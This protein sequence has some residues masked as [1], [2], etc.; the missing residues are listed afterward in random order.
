MEPLSFKSDQ[1]TEIDLLFHKNILRSEMRRDSTGS[2]MWE[3]LLGEHWDVSIH[4]RRV[5]SY[6]R[7][8][9]MPDV[10]ALHKYLS[11]STCTCWEDLDCSSRLFQ[12][13]V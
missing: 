6:Q 11:L 12:R 9:L 7:Y 3:G 13:L 2:V 5:W 1:K 4:I 10:Y 8:L